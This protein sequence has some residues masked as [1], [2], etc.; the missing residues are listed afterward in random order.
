MGYFLQINWEN[1]LKH[2]GLRLR[3]LKTGTHARVLRSSIG[4]TNLEE[5]H[6]DEPVVP[7]SY[8]TLEPGENKVSCHVAWTNEDTKKVILENIH[9]SPLY[10]GQIEGVGPRYCPSLEDKI[11]RFAD[12][13]RHQV[14]IEPCGLDT[15]EMYLQGMSSS[16][17]EEVQLAFYS[18]CKRI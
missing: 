18:Y 10:S 14:F 6:G 2:L 1:S 4:F 7:F 13:E 3:R 17:P 12:K 5:Q 8:D 16:L 9:R 11:V 15:E